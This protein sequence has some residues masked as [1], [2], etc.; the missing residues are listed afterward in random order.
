[1]RRACPCST[2][3]SIG[4]SSIHTVRHR[5]A[6]RCRSLDTGQSSDWTLLVG[7][8]DNAAHL[9]PRVVVGISPI[10]SISRGTISLAG[11]SPSALA[12]SSILFCECLVGALDRTLQDLAGRRLRLLGGVRHLLSLSLSVCLRTGLCEHL[13]RHSWL[14]RRRLDDAAQV[15]LRFPRGLLVTSHLHRKTVGSVLG[16]HTDA[17]LSP[18]RDQICTS[19]TFRSTG[20]CQ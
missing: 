10:Q 15:L 6:P 9:V 18:T 19:L 5:P 3:T 8:E 1:L 17:W 12:A 20:G 13:D 2:I 16:T 14:V 7:F 11:D 4:S